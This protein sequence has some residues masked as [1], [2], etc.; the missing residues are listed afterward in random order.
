VQ[1]IAHPQPGTAHRFERNAAGA[2][3]GALTVAESMP[4]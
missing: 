2:D 4:K 1:R 3:R